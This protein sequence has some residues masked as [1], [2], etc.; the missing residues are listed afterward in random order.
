MQTSYNSRENNEPRPA[1]SPRRK[2]AAHIKKNRMKGTVAP[3]VFI[4]LYRA[5]IIPAP[6][7]IVFILR[8]NLSPINLL[9][10]H[11]LAPPVP[12][13]STHGAHPADPPQIPRRGGNSAPLFAPYTFPPLLLLNPPPPPPT[14]TPPVLPWMMPVG[15]DSG[16]PRQ[17]H[18]RRG[19]PTR[20]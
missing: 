19:G 16:M 6:F 18:R 5:D 4:T 14:H 1:L 20:N 2:T 15:G 9:L 10:G 17:E 13:P 7:P 11:T 8:F 12:P 3:L